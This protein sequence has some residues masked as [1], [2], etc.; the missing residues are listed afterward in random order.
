MKIK[1][2]VLE[3][4]GLFR[5]RNEIDLDTRFLSRFAYASTDLRESP[6]VFQS[7]GMNN[8]CVEEFTETT[9]C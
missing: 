9:A 3:N 1:K 6:I 4:F 2:L 7:K 8:T 5:G